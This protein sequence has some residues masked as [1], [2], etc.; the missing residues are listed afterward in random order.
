MKHQNTIVNGLN[1]EARVIG[2]KEL[3]ADLRIMAIPPQ[4]NLPKNFTLLISFCSYLIAQYSE[5]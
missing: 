1:L 2:S 3:L 5:H 4:L